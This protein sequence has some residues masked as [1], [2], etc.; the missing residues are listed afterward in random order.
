VFRRVGLPN[1]VTDVTISF[2]RIKASFGKNC[3]NVESFRESF[4]NVAESG[5]MLEIQAFLA[6]QY[7]KNKC[8]KSAFLPKDNVSCLL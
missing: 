2:K 1:A 3:Q 8:T 4:Q 5:E 6:S 7:H